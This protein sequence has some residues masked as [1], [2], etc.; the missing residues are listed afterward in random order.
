MKTIYVGNLPFS[1]TE[2]KV[3]D[4]FAARGEVH[5]ISLFHD[6]ATDR[7]RGFGFIDIDDAA[8]ENVLKLDGKGFDGRP[9]RVNVAKKVEDESNTQ[10]AAIID[11]IIE[12]ENLNSI[13]ETEKG[14][15]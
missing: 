12:T 4:V 13:V 5:S 8:L 10:V 6:R 7:F 3:R 15:G 2:E 14:T 11:P 9:M 1:A